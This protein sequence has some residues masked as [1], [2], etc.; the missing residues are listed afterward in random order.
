M[1]ERTLLV[2]RRTSSRTWESNA[3]TLTNSM[4]NHSQTCHRC[5]CNP[6]LGPAP[7]SLRTSSLF[8]LEVLVLS[9]ADSF[10]LFHYHTRQGYP[11]FHFPHKRTKLLASVVKEQITTL[12][13]QTQGDMRSMAIED[14]P[15]DSGGACKLQQL[16]R[17]LS[18]FF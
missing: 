16:L 11:P 13:A 6:T 2:P 18:S 9:A 4:V 7:S 14:P 10:S 1:H 8:L 15:R 3:Y 12:V 17:Y 5:R